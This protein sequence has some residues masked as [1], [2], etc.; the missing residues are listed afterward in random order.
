[1]ATKRNNTWFICPGP[2]I[3]RA[4]NL[5]P[6]SWGFPIQQASKTTFF[7]LQIVEIL[8]QLYNFTIFPDQ[9]QTLLM[10][11]RTAKWY[12]GSLDNKKHANKHVLELI[13]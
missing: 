3:L 6:A 12:S 10:V 11:F 4:P 2:F 9:I 13:V 1:M 7:L 8:Q 5:L